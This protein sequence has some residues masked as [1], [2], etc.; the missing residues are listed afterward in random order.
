MLRAQQER[1]LHGIKVAHNAPEVSHLLFADDSLFFCRAN[2]EE[3][4]AIK[5]KHLANW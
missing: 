4:Q 2:K 1:M 3:A 5:N